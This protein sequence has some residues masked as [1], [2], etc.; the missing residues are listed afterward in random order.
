ML[1]SAALKSS[2]VLSLGAVALL[3]GREALAAASPTTAG[4]IKLLN[5]ALAL[6]HEGINA[7]TLGAKSGLLEKPVLAIA[8]KFQDDHKIHRDLLV[9]TIKHL[10]GT[11]VQELTLADY[12][13]SLGA[14]S[15][16]TQGDVLSF[17]AKLELGATNAYLSILPQFKDSETGKLVA[18]IGND[19]TMHWTL[20]NRALDRPMAAAMSFG[21]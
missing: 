5:A 15:L 19:E 7:Y 14:E 13:K 6:E 18:R 8:V 16:K 4:D 9:G 1:R 10:G 3:S 2:A 21:Q 12:A 11:P 17:A 20:L